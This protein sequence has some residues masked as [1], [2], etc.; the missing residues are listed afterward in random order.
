MALFP[1]LLGA[2]LISLMALVIIIRKTQ[3]KSGKVEC[4][5]KT[6]DVRHLYIPGKDEIGHG[7]DVCSWINELNHFFSTSFGQ[8]K[9][10]IYTP[11]N[12]SPGGGEK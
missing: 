3:W 7:E 2:S 1:I 11:F 12:L 6:V 9:A 10:L 5:L 4:Q 8:Q